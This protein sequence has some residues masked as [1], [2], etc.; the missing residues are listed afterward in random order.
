MKNL[1]LLPSV[2]GSEDR[3]TTSLA[4][5]I[6]RIPELGQALVDF[7]L[8]SS[9]HG[10]DR[11]IEGVDH[12]ALSLADRPDFMLVCEGCNILLEHKLESTLGDTQLERYL[13][14]A[15]KQEKPTFLALISNRRLPVVEAVRLDPTYLKPTDS[16]L[17]HFVWSEVHSLV[18]K[19]KESIAAEFL[20]YMDSLWMR[21]WKLERWGTLF[22]DQDSN[23]VFIEQLERVGEYFRQMGA[24]FRINARG[25]GLEIRKPLPWLHLLYLYA[26]R[27]SKPPTDGIASPHLTANF[28]IDEKHSELAAFKDIFAKVDLGGIPAIAFVGAAPR[29]K[30][31]I[32]H[33]CSYTAALENV[34]DNDQLITHQKLIAFTLGSFDHAKSLVASAKH[35]HTFSNIH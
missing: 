8:D 9:G 1:F 35:T 7:L 21:P 19:R 15:H 10:S 34:L 23:C 25:L 12:P 26:E 33:A 28:W 20:Q 17:P 32:H 4:Y 22:E 13:E 14:L 16:V 3:F 18:Q 24:T 29:W 6:E 5:L 2:I 11:F 30:P 31:N 27:N